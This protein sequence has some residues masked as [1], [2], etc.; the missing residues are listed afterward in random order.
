MELHINASDHIY[1]AQYIS[2]IVCQLPIQI[3]TYLEKLDFHVMK[4]QSIDVILGY[5]L[6]IKLNWIRI[7]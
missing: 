1:Q 5:L 2:G 6:R 7:G 3:D 4:L